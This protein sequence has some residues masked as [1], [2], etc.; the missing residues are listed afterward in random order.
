MNIMNITVDFLA[1]PNL[2][3]GH[4]PPVQVRYKE[5]FP[6]YIIFPLDRGHKLVHYFSPGQ[7]HT[8]PVPLSGSTTGIHVSLQRKAVEH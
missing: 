1:V 8:P 3:R 2:D 5:A 7:G 4:T 6:L